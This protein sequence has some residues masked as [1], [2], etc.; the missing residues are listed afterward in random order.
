MIGCI[1]L[2]GTSLMI[3]LSKTFQM[4][5]HCTPLTEKEWNSPD[6]SDNLLAAHGEFVPA[7]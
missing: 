2:V 5:T 3:N 7:V 6:I 4:R 1:A